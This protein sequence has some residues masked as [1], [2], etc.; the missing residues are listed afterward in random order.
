M[1]YLYG[2]LGNNEEYYDDARLEKQKTSDP[3]WSPCARVIKIWRVLHGKLAASGATNLTI[4]SWNLGVCIVGKEA[5]RERG[6]LR[7]RYHVLTQGDRVQKREPGEN[8][9]ATN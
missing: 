9:S 4:G 8:R 3:K 2:I 6:D 7:W 1:L 5:E